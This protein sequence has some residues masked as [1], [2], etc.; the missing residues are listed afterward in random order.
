MRIWLDLTSGFPV[1]FDVARMRDDLHALSSGWLTH[2]DTGLSTDFRAILLKSRFGETSGPKSQQPAW[3]FGDFRRTE[4][5]ER[6]PYFREL[7]DQLLCPQGRVP[8]LLK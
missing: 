2:Y 1:R 6:L 5:V 3:D 8:R 4:Y 7:M